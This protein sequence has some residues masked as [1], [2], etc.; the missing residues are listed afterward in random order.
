[1]CVDE[2]GVSESEGEGRSSMAAVRGIFVGTGRDRSGSVRSC[3]E[4]KAVTVLDG[5]DS[6]VSTF[7]IF[8]ERS[9]AM[10]SVGSHS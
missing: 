9:S 5:G 1:V 2:D 4:E 8:G 3:G 6:V 7:R 10:R